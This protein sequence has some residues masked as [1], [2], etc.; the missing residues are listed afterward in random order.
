MSKRSNAPIYWVL[1]GAGG[2][3]AALT[4]PALVAV[5]G[6]AVPLGLLPTDLLAYDNALALARHPLGKCLLLAVVV[7]YLWHAAH[8][9]YKSL[10]DLGIRP[11]PWSRRACYGSASLAT[12]LAV[13][14][15]LAVGF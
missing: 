2:M 4:G 12:V 5:T 14:A 7:L 1:F 13:L 11:G 15:L 9:I 10:H 6:I 3:L 8:R